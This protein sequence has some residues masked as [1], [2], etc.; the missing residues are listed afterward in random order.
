MTGIGSGVILAYDLKE[1]ALAATNE[2]ARVAQ[3]LGINKAARVT[4]IKPAGTSSLVLGSAS[5]I[6]AWHNDFYLRRMRIGKNEALYQYLAKTNPALV[7]D[8]FFRPDEMA[9]I[10]IPQEAP[11]GS[12]LRTEKP[13]ELLERVKRFNVEWV[14]EGHRDGDNKNNVSCTISLKDN[15]WEECGSW[16]W[17]NR[18]I[19]NGISVLPYNGG[20]YTQAPFED[21]TEVEFRELE[22]HLNN[23]DLSQVTEF[24]DNTDLKGE[25]ACSGGGCSVDAL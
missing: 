2:N 12:I 21:I 17:E 4:T 3:L 1:A 25:A 5:G 15:E 19:Y 22:G 7:E 10:T 9:C 8:E 11:K 14:H 6:H 23:V 20:T 13:L 18:G 16:M 24:V